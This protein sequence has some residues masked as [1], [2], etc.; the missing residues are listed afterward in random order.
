MKRKHTRLWSALLLPISLLTGCASA[1]E[2]PIYYYPGYEWHYRGVIS[3]TS[4]IP[5]LA[6]K[7]DDVWYTTI[8]YTLSSGRYI[9]ETIWYRQEHRSCPADIMGQ[10]LRLRQT[11]SDGKP[12]SVWL[13]IVDS[14]ALY[15]A[16][17]SGPVTYSEADYPQMHKELK[18]I[19]GLD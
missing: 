2:S 1:G 18:K 14:P 11:G 16:W 10:I 4:T 5:L 6:W 8:V 9:P 13:E 19:L 15:D 17:V 7:T 3:E 12:V